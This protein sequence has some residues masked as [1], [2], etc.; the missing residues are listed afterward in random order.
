MRQGAI[1][2]RGDYFYDAAS[3]Q[4]AHPSGLVVL[5]RHPKRQPTAC[6]HGT[7]VDDFDKPRRGSVQ[8]KL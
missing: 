2:H 8:I 3:K 7:E 4:F 6:R 1:R 5:T